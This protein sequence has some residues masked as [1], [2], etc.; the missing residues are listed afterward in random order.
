MSIKEWL[1]EFD[2]VEQHDYKILLPISHY[3]FKNELNIAN[4]KIIRIN[5][6]AFKKKFYKCK[7]TV[8]F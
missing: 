7:F 6:H 8:L 5:D 4:L 2:S 3:D 1:Q